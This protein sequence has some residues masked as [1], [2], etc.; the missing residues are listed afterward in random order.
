MLALMAALLMTAPAALAQVPERWLREF[1]KL[2]AANSLID[3][4]EIVDDGNVRDSIPPIYQPRFV[5]AADDDKTGPLEPVLSV[6]IGGEARAYPIAI[7][8]WHEIVND[9]I[10][11]VPIAATYCPLCNSGVVF[12]RRLD[13][14]TLL[15]GNTGRIRHYD[16]VMFDHGT[17]SWWQ[18]FSGRAII[19]QLA[20]R[21]MKPIPARVESLSSF[22]ERFADGLLLVPDNPRAR[23]YG[24]TP[25]AGLER[26]KT[27]FGDAPLG[28][29]AGIGPFDY[30]VVV[31]DEA[32]PL[33][34]LRQ[35][36]SMMQN[37]LRFSWTSGRNSIHSTRI[38]SQGADLGN[39]AVTRNGADIAH[40]IVFAFA[41]DAFV[42]DGTWH[43]GE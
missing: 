34:R 31:G 6:A 11:G 21:K 3:F 43:L 17:E 38:I 25:Y 36:G 12:D 9:E 42:P 29:P 13:G 4:S 19:G 8:L 15:L 35:A 24:Q 20:G 30:V 14:E 41:F 16:M 27:P 23:P 5:R 40:D 28:L 32:W 22:V 7:L 37:G 18:Q 2:D 33:A 1:P 26:R 10:G 39:V